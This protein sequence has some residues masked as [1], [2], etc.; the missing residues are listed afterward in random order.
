LRKA[1][2]LINLVEVAREN[3]SFGNGI[4][5]YAGASPPHLAKQWAGE[6]WK[7]ASLPLS[8]QDGCGGC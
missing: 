5:R 4:A 6:V 1:D 7:R 2:V 3:W 8:D